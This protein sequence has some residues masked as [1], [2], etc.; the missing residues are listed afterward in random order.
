M[1]QIM[2]YKYDEA[3]VEEVAPKNFSKSSSWKNFLIFILLT[4]IA[5]A[6]VFI[7]TYHSD[8]Y[9]KEE[10]DA[11]YDSGYEL[12]HR[13]G[14]SSGYF[15][16]FTKGSDV[17]IGITDDESIPYSA[18]YVTRTGSKYHHSWC[19]YVS[20]KS[21]LWY[22]DSASEAELDGYSACSVCF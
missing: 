20:G 17:D 1:R 19:Q 10:V 21:D 22:Y 14:Y 15:A 3:H 13:N 11:A 18:V 16:G 4:I 6:A 12:G 7:F 8:C 5:A 2:E 9:T